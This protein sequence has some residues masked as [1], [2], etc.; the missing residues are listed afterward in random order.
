VLNAGIAKSRCKFV[1]L[2]AILH[3]L[4]PIVTNIISAL[5]GVSSLDYIEKD[6]QK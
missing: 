6:I 2:V 4:L 1:I 3:F 5:D